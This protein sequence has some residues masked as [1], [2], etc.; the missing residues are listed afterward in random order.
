MRAQGPYVPIRELLNLLQAVPPPPQPEAYLVIAGRIHRDL[1]RKE[2]GQ[3]VGGG[4]EAQMML[5]VN[6]RVAEH[7]RHQLGMKGSD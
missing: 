3:A 4:G 7:H 6:E 2:V 1:H 5:A